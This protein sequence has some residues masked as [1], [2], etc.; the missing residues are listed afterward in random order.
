MKRLRIEGC[1]RY[2]G[3]QLWHLDGVESRIKSN[4][5]NRQKPQHLYNTNQQ[6]VIS[7]TSA[8]SRFKDKVLVYRVAVFLGLYLVSGLENPLD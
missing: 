4:L 3:T 1:E 5:I 2:P 7:T 6:D 8:H